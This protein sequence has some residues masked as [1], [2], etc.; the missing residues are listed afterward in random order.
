MCWSA[1]VHNAQEKWRDREEEGCNK[2]ANRETEESNKQT[3]TLSLMYY[4]SAPSMRHTEHISTT[5]LP[6]IIKR[7]SLAWL[8]VESPLVVSPSACTGVQP[9]WHVD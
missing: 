9:D 5:Q 6:D 8:L 1:V 2:M 4:H 3:Q 7:G